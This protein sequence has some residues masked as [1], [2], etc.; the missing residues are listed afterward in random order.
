MMGLRKRVEKK[1]AAHRKWM[2]ELDDEHERH[3]DW[4][5]E[6]RRQDYVS[7]RH[8]IRVAMDFESCIGEEPDRVWIEDSDIYLQCEDLVFRFAGWEKSAFSCRRGYYQV[9]GEHGGFS[10]MIGSFVD[11]DH[12][13]KG[14]DNFTVSYPPLDKPIKEQWGCEYLWDRVVKEKMKKYRIKEFRP[15]ADG[16]WCKN[17][18]RFR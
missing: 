8:Q 2:K 11:L 14:G 15:M 4:L 10:R 18:E 5:R 9:R 13:I 7:T 17:D 3:Q 1:A 12:L 6:A 16:G